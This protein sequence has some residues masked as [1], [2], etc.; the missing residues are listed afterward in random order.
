MSFV[1]YMPYKNLFSEGLIG[2]LRTKNRLVMPPM[3]RNYADPEGRVTPR[4][5]EHIRRISQGGVG[6]IILEASFI[7][8]EGKGFRNE[9]GINSDDLVPG[10][11]DLV[12]AAHEHDVRIGPQLYHAGR[13]TSAKVTGA[14]PLAPSAVPDPSSG[15]M[16][17]AL[18]TPEIARLV[19]EYGRAAARAKSAGCDFVEIHGAHGYL[20][21]QFL[22]PFSNIREDEYGGSF[23]NRFRFLH[24]V[25]LS[26]RKAVGNDFPV[27]VRLSG[28]ELVD[29]GI[30]IEDT[31]QVSRELEKLGVAA[32]HISAGNYASYASGLMIPPMAIADGPLVY[33]A[34]AVKKTVK[35]P[36]IAVGKI[37]SPELAEQVL[38]DGKADFIAI[39]RT[40]LADPDWPNK[41]REGREEEVM[42]CF[43]CNQ[44]CITRLFAQEEVW[45]TVNPETS[46]EKEFSQPPKKK[47]KV[48]VVGGGPAG[49]SA[50]KTAALRGHRVVLFEKEN[51]L[52]GQ[53]LLAG[54]VPH[55]QGWRRLGVKLS[56]DLKR[57]AVDVRLKSPVKAN[58]IK[59]EK[60]DIVVLA[61]GST[62]GLPPIPGAEGEM[63]YFARDVLMGRAKVK[64]NCVLIGGGS[65]GV[66]VAEFLAAAGHPVTV[67]EISSQLAAHMPVDERALLLKRL[68]AWHAIILTESD[69]KRIDAGEVVVSVNGVE[70]R[71]PADTVVL[72]IGSRPEAALAEELRSLSLEFKIV[73]DAKQPRNVTEA[74]AEG[75]LAILS[76]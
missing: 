76:L 20:I 53:L 38:A 13:Q 3:V 63:V 34:E 11:S 58:L 75:A 55:R 14:Q 45:C 51:Y 8:P 10:L 68:E 21:T 39:G 71:V 24:E 61:T 54:A 4:Y 17:R 74:M 29:G 31:I 16:P 30:S 5:L 60:P 2:H 23:E 22:S 36:V 12:K 18:T 35:I 73:G 44:G 15:E 43:A 70:R 57:L 66:E 62:P 42:P 33:L 7:S 6:T 40:L 25:Y 65:S 37:R 26:V 67:V 59:A 69:V 64:G 41:V 56:E 50:A 52:G 72:C 47:K 32:V 49:M 1:I 19:Q 46:R 48:V 9:L 27:T 28:D